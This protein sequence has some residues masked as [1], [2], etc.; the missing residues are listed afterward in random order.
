M[1][2]LDLDELRFLSKMEEEIG[3]CL[4]LYVDG[5]KYPRASDYTWLF[6]DVDFSSFFVAILRFQSAYVFLSRLFHGSSVQ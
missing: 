6:D 3:S 5:L 1:P 4:L 2:T